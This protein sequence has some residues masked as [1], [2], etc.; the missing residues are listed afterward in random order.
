[1]DGDLQNVSY[2][3]TPAITLRHLTFW[4]KRLSPFSHISYIYDNDSY[5]GS[6]YA[7]HSV[8]CIHFKKYGKTH[9]QFF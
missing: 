7:L 3:V 9:L 5:N 6:R 4:S 1:M 2:N 8:F